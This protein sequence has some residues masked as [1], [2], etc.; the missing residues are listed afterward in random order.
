MKTLSWKHDFT[1]NGGEVRHRVVGQAHLAEQ[2]RV[3]TLAA[4]SPPEESI[5][6]RIIGRW[7]LCRVS[8]AYSL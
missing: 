4:Y 7:I 5:Q 6:S 1:P 2:G 8:N 3:S